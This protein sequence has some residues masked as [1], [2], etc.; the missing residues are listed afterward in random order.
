MKYE[1]TEEYRFEG[2][3]YSYVNLDFDQIATGGALM[4]LH[5]K[6]LGQLPASDQLL[7]RNLSI[8]M[9][10]TSFVLFIMGQITKLPVE[11][12]YGL[13]RRE[14]MSLLS[15]AIEEFQGK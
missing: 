8:S 1:F 5:S 13:P 7:N 14:F 4:S 12:F 9:L 3:S 6:Y 15:A 2:K 11:F 10:D